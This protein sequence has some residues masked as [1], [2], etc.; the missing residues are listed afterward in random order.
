MEGILREISEDIKARFD[1]LLKVSE[2]AEDFIIQR[3][4]NPQYGVRE[5]RR[6]I[7]GLVQMPLS[8]LILSRKFKEHKEW[9][10]VCKDEGIEM[11]PLLINKKE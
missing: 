4:Y 11:V 5:L 10:V 9:Q 3:G 1:A 2:E 8:N 7:E 6:N